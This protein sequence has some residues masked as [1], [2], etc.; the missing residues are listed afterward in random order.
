MGN[1]L[2][3][4]A[5][6]NTDNYVWPV[7]AGLT[8]APAAVPKT[9]QTTADSPGDDGAYRWG[10]AWPN[11]R[12]TTNG[13][14]TVRD[15]LTGLIWAPDG[16]LMPTRDTSFDTDGT[17]NDGMVT[18]QHALNYVVMLNSQSYLGFSDW[19]LP[20]VNEFDSLEHLG[21]ASQSCG[22]PPCA[23]PE[24]W[25]NTQGFS[26]VHSIRSSYWSS[27]S[28]AQNLGN[29]AWNFH[30]YAGKASNYF[31]WPVRGG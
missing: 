24:A 9:G 21:Y 14:T 27:T 30:S 13:D 19:R 4:L 1:G 26:N 17:L 18:W 2:H 22:G 6:A 5:I 23:T 10:V 31:V 3:G 25:L 8:T 11:P 15:N 28:W 7:R 12:F 16:N 29:F 20:N